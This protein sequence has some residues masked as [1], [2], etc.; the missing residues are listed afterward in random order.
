MQKHGHTANGKISPTYYTWR[1][2]IDRCTN[3]QH[4]H[5]AR[6]G[7]SGVT[8]CE[9]WR[10][11]TN[12]LEDMGERPS[13]MTLDREKSEQGYF[14]ENCRWATRKEQARQNR[15]LLT[16]NG[17]TRSV[18]EWAKHIGV[19]QQTLSARLTRYGWPVERALTQGG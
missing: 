14:R 12:F 11:F 18:G 2:M 6:Y 7:G 1:A 10:V 13:G 3:P 15:K 9:R 4:P 17:E 5:Y 19:K 16:F 8:V